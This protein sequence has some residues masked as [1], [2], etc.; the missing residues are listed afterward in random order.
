MSLYL[1]IG[2]FPWKLWVTQTQKERKK[3]TSLLNQ[4]LPHFAQ[5]LR[6]HL[7]LIWVVSLG[8]SFSE[9]FFVLLFKKHNN[10]LGYPRR[11]W[12]IT[13]RLVSIIVLQQHGGGYSCIPTTNLCLFLMYCFW[14]SNLFYRYRL[15]SKC[16]SIRHVWQHQSI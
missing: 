12:T 6:T 5:N 11:M 14:F 3:H 10:I 2:A 15:H 4:W 1:K 16:R 8:I 7:L 13:V 9:I